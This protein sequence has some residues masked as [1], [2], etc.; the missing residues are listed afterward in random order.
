MDWIKIS[1][2]VFLLLML[3][4][5]LPRAKQMFTESPKAESGDWQAALMPLIGV[6]AF[7]ALLA[8]LVSQ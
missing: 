2:A 1:S 4:F 5:L 3:F 6:I 8:W 7:V